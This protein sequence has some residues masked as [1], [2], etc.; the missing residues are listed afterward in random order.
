MCLKSPFLVHSSTRDKLKLG[1]QK[2]IVKCAN[3]SEFGN[4]SWMPNSR[5]AKAAVMEHVSGRW[6]S[7]YFGYISGIMDRVGVTVY[8]PSPKSI[9]SQLQLHFLLQLN[10]KVVARNLPAIKACGKWIKAKYVEESEACRCLA[11]FRMRAVGFGNMA[12]RTGR[13]YRM[14]WCPLCPAGTPNSERHIAVMCMRIEEEREQLGLRRRINI[15]LLDG[16]DEEEVYSRWLRGVASTWE[17]LGRR[18]WFEIG[19]LLN[20]LLDKWLSLW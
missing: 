17:T 9:M 8:L 13:N 18:E 1:L 20:I 3:H 4:S 11:K 10:E 19:G 15:G 14:R 5:W 6:T 7:L 2:G 16:L 12:P